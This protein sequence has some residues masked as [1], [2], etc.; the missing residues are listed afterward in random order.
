MG[1]QVDRRS[2]GLVHQRPGCPSRPGARHKPPSRKNSTP[3]PTVKVLSA[4]KPGWLTDIQPGSWCRLRG[5]C[6]KACF[7]GDSC[8]FLSWGSAVRWS[9]SAIV[10]L[11]TGYGL[12]GRW[13]ID[14]EWVG[15][16]WR[17]GQSVGRNPS[18]PERRSFKIASRAFP[19]PSVP[20]V[21]PRDAS[22][23]GMDWGSRGPVLTVS[24][25]TGMPKEMG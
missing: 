24:Q 19:D 2:H 25:T 12:R 23:R 11:A 21:P 18:R 9:R 15:T 22:R 7:P 8:G 17:G 1:L 20:I 16:R 3:L 6:P 14:T 13:M 10:S 5:G 4:S